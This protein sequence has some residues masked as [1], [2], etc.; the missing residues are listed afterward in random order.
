ME[1]INI[2]STDFHL[3]EFEEVKELLAGSDMLAY[4]LKQLKEIWDDIQAGREVWL[5]DRYKEQDCSRKKRRSAIS[6]SGT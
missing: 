1:R 4:S 5:F 2:V 6:E 3:P